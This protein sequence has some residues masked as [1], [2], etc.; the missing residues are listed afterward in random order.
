MKQLLLPIH[1][2]DE[3]SLAN[4][5]SD[6][7]LLLL[8]S[9]QKNL[10]LL[11]QPFFYVWGESSSGKSHLLKALSNDLLREECSAIYVPLSKCQYFSPLVL[12]NLE[13]KHL[14]CLDDVDQI[15]GDPEWELALF[16][17]MNRI[18]EIGKTLLLM[19]AQVSP[20]ALSIQLPDLRSRL[21]WGEIYQLEP[22]N[23]KQKIQ[24]L[25]QN[26][27]DR[28]IELPDEVA[29]FLLKRLD[30]NMHN[31]LNALQT[32]DQASL[33]AQRKLTIPFV[34]EILKL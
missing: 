25:Q 30:R 34:K 6:N 19:S 28:G 11:T 23:D 31:L 18:K 8:D 13:Y 9:L 29:G 22:L 16:D 10:V 24:V 14:V 26:S 12:E 33:Q 5:Y 7:H 2:F 32:L 21:N 4:F 17:L 1:Q 27:R 20:K 3:E 15:M